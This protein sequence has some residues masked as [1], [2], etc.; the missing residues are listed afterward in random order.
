MITPNTVLVETISFDGIEAVLYTRIGANIDDL[1]ATK[2]AEL[3]VA[4][5]T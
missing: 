1:T 2:L 3:A 4:S 5:G